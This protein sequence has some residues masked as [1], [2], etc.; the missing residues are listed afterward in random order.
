MATPNSRKIAIPIQII[1][2]N[3]QVSV[4]YKGMDTNGELHGQMT[5]SKTLRIFQMIFVLYAITL[6]HLTHKQEL[7]WITSNWSCKLKNL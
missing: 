4:S 2:K 7:T 3:A 6:I 5:R 1:G